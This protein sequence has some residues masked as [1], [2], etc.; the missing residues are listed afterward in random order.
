MQAVIQPAL[1]EALTVIGTTGVPAMA[2]GGIVLGPTFAQIGE[3]G[4]EA[5]IP[6]S[7]LGDMSGGGNSGPVTIITELD[8]QVIARNTLDRMPR[9]VRIRGRMRG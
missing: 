5:V 6:L 8:G 4:P 7:R 1:G 2:E 3:A 9:L